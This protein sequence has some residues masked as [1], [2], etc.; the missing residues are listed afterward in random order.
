MSKRDKLEGAIEALEAWVPDRYMGGAEG[1]DIC[2]MDVAETVARLRAQLAAL[3]PEPEQL[4]TERERRLWEALERLTSKLDEVHKSREYAAVWFLA[5]LH[6][7]T[8]CG[9]T[10]TKELEEAVSVLADTP[11]PDAEIKPPPPTPEP[12]RVKGKVVH[13]YI[14]PTVSLEVDQPDPRDEALERA[15]K[16]FKRLTIDIDEVRRA[17]DQQWVDRNNRV[18]VT[19]ITRFTYGDV[20]DADD[21]LAAIRA[22]RGGK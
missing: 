17:V 16:I 15:E 4:W 10:Y 22:A 13:R 8:Y 14:R 9:P 6:D 1:G 5:H 18:S 2:S 7:G 11:L 3:P 19:H 20:I 21:A 12:R